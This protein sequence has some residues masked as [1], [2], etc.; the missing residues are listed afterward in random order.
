MSPLILGAILIAIV[1]CAGIWIA[2]NR[3]ASNQV[4]E[5]SY[6]YNPGDSDFTWLTQRRITDDDL[7]GMSK[8]DIRLLRNTIYALHG[9]KFISPELTAYF[10]QF[11][12]YRPTK[13]EI[14]I[15][16]L[17][18]TEQYNITFLKAREQ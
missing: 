11:S 10:S 6:T 9:R 1:A 8:S 2:I 7:R 16:D 13:T 5:T 14:D 4:S 15:S 3:G 12:W 18:Q 17:S